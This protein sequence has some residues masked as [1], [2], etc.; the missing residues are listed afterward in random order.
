MS[1]F[2]SNG[3]QL[4]LEGNY[5]Y[6]RHIATYTRFI[7]QHI[8]I[9][10]NQSQALYNFPKI[11]EG[12]KADMHTLVKFFRRRIPC[13]CLDERYE[14]V[15][16]ITKIAFCYNPRCRFLPCV[17]MKRSSTMYCSRCRC[18]TYCSRWCQKSDWS[19]HKTACDKC[20][21]IKAYF[22]ADQ[23]QNI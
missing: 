2:L 16:N 1:Y 13:S 17:E 7:E 23:Q 3:A 21:D 20:F 4:I 5:D 11:L 10:L 14:E 18:V 9:E 22:E 15:K 6:A 12:Y 19:R 8:A